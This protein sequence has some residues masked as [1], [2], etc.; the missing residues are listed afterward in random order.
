MSPENGHSPGTSTTT[1]LCAHLVLP[2]M[3]QE[4]AADLISSRR[5]LLPGFEPAKVKMAFLRSILNHHGV[6]YSRC[7]TKSDLVELF[8]EKIR[9]L[10]V[11]LPT[12]GSFVVKHRSHMVVSYSMRLSERRRSATD[13]FPRSGAR[14]RRALC[15]LILTKVLRDCSSRDKPGAQL[16]ISSIIGHARLPPLSSRVASPRVVRISMF[17]VDST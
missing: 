13:A 5:Y 7:R 12:A 8:N 11:S 3:P 14:I 1:V 10:G 4:C 17:L 15:L 6:D 9:P 2:I 16:R